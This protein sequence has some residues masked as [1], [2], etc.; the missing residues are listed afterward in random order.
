MRRLRDYSWADWRRLRPLGH[1]YK[2][3]IYRTFTAW[4]V[5]RRSPGIA[6]IVNEVRTRN[7][8]TLAVPIA[9]EAPWAIRHQVAAARRQF[10]DAMLVV[11]DNSRNEDAAHEIE[12]ICR[13][14]GVAYL[15]LPVDPSKKGSRSHAMAINWVYR[16]LVCAVTPSC[17]AFLDHDLFPTK[18]VFFAALIEHQPIYGLMRTAAHRWYLWAGFC[19]FDGRYAAAPVLDFSQ[20]WFNGLDT[21][22]GN[23]D[24]LYRTLDRGALTFAPTRFEPYRPGADPAHASIQW[25]GTWLHEVGSTRRD[26]LSEIAADKRRTI[27]QLLAARPAAADAPARDAMVL[28]P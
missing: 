23:W 6:S 28:V 2:T 15:R 17:F 5:R 10:K 25:C 18:P 4:H 9:F 1:A 8:T 22:G 3:A 21:G 11:C 12:A 24:A 13:E 14:A 20:D 27:K 26:G 16:N 19:V 7:Q